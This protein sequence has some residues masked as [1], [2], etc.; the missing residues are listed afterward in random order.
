M[1][2]LF[3]KY[4]ILNKY[5]EDAQNYEIV[6]LFGQYINLCPDQFDNI[7]LMNK[8]SLMS[9]ENIHINSFMFEPIIDMSIKSL[10]DLFGRVSIIA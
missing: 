1:F 7:L 5:Q 8:V 4:D 6:K 3:T 10:V 2:I 9:S